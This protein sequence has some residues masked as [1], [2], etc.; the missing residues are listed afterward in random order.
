MR[1]DRIA[2]R[3]VLAAAV[4]A[5]LSGPGSTAAQVNGQSTV[6]IGEQIIGATLRSQQ[7]EELGEIEEVV[8]DPRGRIQYLIVSHGGWLDI[9][10]ENIAVPWQDM[11]MRVG[12][13]QVIVNVSR[14]QVAQAFAGE[15]DLIGEKTSPQTNVYRYR[16]QLTGGQRTD[17]APA[18]GTQ[19]QEE[20]T[21]SF[22]A[23]DKNDDGMISK[24]EATRSVDLERRFGELD[25]NG[26]GRLDRAEYAAFE[27]EPSGPTTAIAEGAEGAGAGA[28]QSAPPPTQGGQTPSPAA[29]RQAQTV[30][31]DLDENGDGA[32]GPQEAAVRPSLASRFE[33]Y[34]ADGDGH[35]AG[36]EFQ[37]YARDFVGTAETEMAERT[38]MWGEQ[39]IDIPEPG[40]TPPNPSL[41]GGGAAQQPAQAEAPPQATGAGGQ[42]DRPGG[43]AEQ[44]QIE[45]GG[46]QGAPDGQAGAD[47]EPNFANLDTD[48]DG[49]LTRQEAQASRRLTERFRDYDRDGD[50]R[51]TRAEFVVYAALAPEEG[52]RTAAFK[53][54]D[55]NNDGVV[56]QAEAEG[57]ARLQ[58]RFMELDS[59]SDGSLSPSEFAAFE[60]EAG[61]EGAPPAPDRSGQGGGGQAPRQNPGNQGA[62]GR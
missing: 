2:R 59:D 47:E 31:Q 42:Q 44:R 22:T 39:R 32:I 25:L 34:D 27:I 8:A 50:G 19:P 33:Q 38:P 23:L 49:V 11:E 62:G 53:Q 51:L 21:V 28:V 30:F 57:S 15:R 29:Q 24:Q 12:A 40:E 54:L 58:A 18:R 60:Q 45:P 48:E 52:E 10:D 17:V 35:I 61:A 16:E 3:T 4:A 14:D 41:Q 43:I 26:D 55:A 1:Q 37:A 6:R 56:S 46:G 5:L 36:K 13:G 9:G 7:G 20:I